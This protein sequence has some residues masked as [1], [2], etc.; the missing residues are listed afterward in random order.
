MRMM[1]HTPT[2]DMLG[3]FPCVLAT[4]KND[5]VPLCAIP[6]QGVVW[7]PTFLSQRNGLPKFWNHL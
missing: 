6:E 3:H 4:E 7:P 1:I 2:S 5:E